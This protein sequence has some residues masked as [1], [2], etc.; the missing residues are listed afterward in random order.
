MKPEYLQLL[1]CPDCQGNLNLSGECNADGKL[2]SGLLTCRSCERCFP[3]RGFIPRFFESSFYADSFGPQWKTFAKTQLDSRQTRE[4]EIRF[5]SEID[6]RES[7][8]SGK[9]IIE[10]GSGAGRFVDVVSRLKPKLA[11]GLD[12]SD[13][14]D[15]AQANLGD[16]DNVFIVQADIF[17]PP[18]RSG[19]FDFAYSIGVMHHTPDPPGAFRKMVELTKLNG[20]VGVSLYEISLYERPNL[21]SLKVSTVELLWAVNMWRCE[22]F[23][24]IT[25]RIP[26]SWFLAYC[27]YFVPV[28]HWVNKIPVLGNV[29]YL[30]PAT[31][32]K[33]LPVG[34]SMV[35]TH[36]TY[37]TKIVHQYRHKDVFQWFLRNGLHSIVVNNGR[38]GWV[39]LTGTK[40]PAAL[41]E[42]MQRAIKEQ[43]LGPGQVGS[44]TPSATTI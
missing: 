20:R 33:H 12:A 9:T 1:C 16:R 28:L 29:R 2:E 10:L 30:F 11:I 25:T 27:K 36:D 32:Y 40:S 37:A 13:A 26:E 19:S 15:A 18:F 34:W 3:I 14:V 39:S 44:F 35:D 7:E 31:C 22:F 5:E 6:W 4:S 23:R 8:L 43:P 41:V 21:N 38:A 42:E 17:K 24:A